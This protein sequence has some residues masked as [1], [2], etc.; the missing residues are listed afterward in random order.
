MT[1]PLPARR[2]S[3]I[4]TSLDHIQCITSVGALPLFRGMLH[5]EVGEGESGKTWIA[6]HAVLDVARRGLQVVALDGEM[7]GPSWR[8]RADAIGAT[9]AELELIAYVEMDARSADPDAIAATCAELAADGR[10]PVAL[11]VWDSALS[12]LS[13]TARSEND[14][15]EVSRVY[16]RLRETVRRT[17]AAGL[18]VDHSA[19]GSSTL[20]SRGATAKFNALDI[21]YGVR[22]ADDSV[23][24][25]IDPWSSIVSV[26]KDRHGLL[27]KLGDRE[28]S[29]FPL[30]QGAL[31]LSITERDTFTHR[32]SA[33]NPIAVA[34]A[35]I[36]DLDP[37]PRSANDA[38]GRIRGNRQAVLRA[39]KLWKET[40]S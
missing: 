20:I 33:E 9:D 12:M 24:G 14:N 22:L 8:R 34:L 36:T 1:Q 16:D 26:E 37:P 19:R 32:L 31:D 4:A 7:S 35:K 17:T 29:F 13:R 3:T 27:G 18:I 23:P 25:P 40:E 11:I 21:S 5:A 30:G 15:A 2:L 28:A 6:C 10:P 39:F 38:H